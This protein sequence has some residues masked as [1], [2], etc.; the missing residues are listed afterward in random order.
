M[1]R[2]QMTR[3][4]KF[5]LYFLSAYLVAMLALILIKFIQKLHGG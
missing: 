5:G 4:T 1:P 2:I 3:M